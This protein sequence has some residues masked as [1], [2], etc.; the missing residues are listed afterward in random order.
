VCFGL[1]LLS[2]LWV[3]PLFFGNYCWF[4]SV[5]GLSSATIDF[6]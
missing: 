4:K 3:S 2:A 5:H 1:G 6:H